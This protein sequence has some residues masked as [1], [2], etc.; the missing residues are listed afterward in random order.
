MKRERLRLPDIL[1]PA[2]LPSTIF[3]DLHWSTQAFHHSVSHYCPCSYVSVLSSHL[4]YIVS[5]RLDIRAHFPGSGKTFTMEGD[6]DNLDKRGMIPRSMEHVF[7]TA[8]K[9]K[10]NGWKVRK[11]RVSTQILRCQS[12]AFLLVSGFYKF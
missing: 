6:Q 4:L 8:E 10:E 12:F 2:S 1:S 9:L 7:E 5:T 3:F 11:E